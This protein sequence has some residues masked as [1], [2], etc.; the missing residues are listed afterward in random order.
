MGGNTR[1]LGQRD[2]SQKTH[3]Q[4]K[5]QN[6]YKKHVLHAKESLLLF[7]MNMEKATILRLKLI[8]IA[9]TSFCYKII[10]SLC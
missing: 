3:H 10:S 5:S 7:V 4:N 8:K 2:G 9:L 6:N 1:L